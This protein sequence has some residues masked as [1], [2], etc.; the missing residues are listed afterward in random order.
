[1][2]IL[3][4][5]LMLLPVVQGHAQFT[6]KDFHLMGTVEH[7]A[8]GKLP[9]YTTFGFRGELL[10]GNSFGSEFGFSGSRDNIH[11][12]VGILSPLALLLVTSNNDDEERSG[13]LAG[14][15]LFLACA[16]TFIEHTNYHIR[17]TDSF[18]IVPFLSLARFRYMYDR[19]DPFYNT[20][21]FV[22][23]S[24]GTKLSLLSRE[25]FVL[26]LSAERTQLYHTGRPAG[27]QT[28]I[29]MGYRFKNISGFF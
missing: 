10:F 17:I 20:D 1:M 26:N 27:F 15:A 25:N 22:S 4:V 18:E 6:M 29:H 28:G 2:R 23:W 14:F 8:I 3:C 5:I 13:S 12:G 21:Q 11:V 19:T 9:A 16:V 24:V 7:I